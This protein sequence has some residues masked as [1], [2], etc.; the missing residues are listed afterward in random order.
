M[1]DMQ[2]ALGSCVAGN[3]ELKDKLDYSSRYSS[4]LKSNLQL[5]ASDAVSNPV[6]KTSSLGEGARSKFKS[7]NPHAALQH[8]KNSS[9]SVSSSVSNN[10]TESNM[11]FGT[12]IN[13]SLKEKTDVHGGSILS[14]DAKSDRSTY[15]HGDQTD[16]DG[17]KLPNYVLKQQRRLNSRKAKVVIGVGTKHSD[18]RV[19]GAPEPERQLFIYRVDRQTVTEDL[20]IYIQEA[21]ITMCS[22]VCVSKE[23]SKFKSFKLSVP[24]SQFKRLFDNQMWPEGIRVRQFYMP[25]GKD[26]KT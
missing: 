15:G 12:M 8:T 10:Q 17:F 18:H 16:D 14:L 20:K 11:Y 24:L 1:L 26:N 9:Q 3:L 5:N 6:Y 7:L 21:G 2:E 22:L 25:K 19:R 13:G 4:L 23:D